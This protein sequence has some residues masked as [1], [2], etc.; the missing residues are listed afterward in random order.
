MHAEV[1]AMSGTQRVLFP[2]NMA[3]PLGEGD[4]PLNFYVTAD[5]TYLYLNRV[6]SSM[7]LAAST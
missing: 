3:N 2:E 5:E 6:G 7:P 1:M 4:G